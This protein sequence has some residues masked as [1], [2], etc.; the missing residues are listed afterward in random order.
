MAAIVEWKSGSGNGSWFVNT[1]WLGDAVPTANSDVY[2]YGGSGNPQIASPGAVAAGVQIGY[3]LAGQLT[4]TG[5]GT[6]NSSSAS[7]SF[8][9]LATVTGAGSQWNAGEIRVGANANGTSGTLNITNGGLMTGN[10]ARVADDL[11]GPDNSIGTV[12][13]D[14][15][16]WNVTGQLFLGNTGHSKA[17]FTVQNGGTASHTHA[18]VQGPSSGGPTNVTVDGIGSTWTLN[19]SQVTDAL[20]IWSNGATSTVNIVNGASV[21]VNSGTGTVRLSGSGPTVLN[22]GNGGAAGALNA[23]E[24]TGS[25][26]AT[27]N[28]NHTGVAALTANLTGNLTISKLG[29]GTM[30]LTG[31]NTYTGTTTI[32]EGTLR[33]A[34]ATA[35]L[36]TG[37]VLNNGTLSI[38]SDGTV[39]V[40]NAISGS[41]NLQKSGLGTLT[42][43]GVN[44][45]AGGTSIT[46]GYIN[47]ASLSNFGTG[48][49]TCDG[50]G[51]QWA[52][53]NTVDISAK[54]NAIGAGGASFN[55]N[56]NNVTLATAL[57]GS[58]GI[59]K[60]GP[61][62]LTLNGANQYSGGTTVSGGTLKKGVA[63]ALP[64]N[65]ALTVNG[66][67]LD[68]NNFNT[69]VSSLSV[70]D[71]S[72]I[73]GTA[74]LTVNQSTNTTSSGI[75]TGAGGL[76][77]QG[78]GRLALA[79]AG[80]TYTGP[81]N[82][83]GGALEIQN[84]VSFNSPIF[85][86]APAALTLNIA[87]DVR[88]LQGISGGGSIDVTGTAKTARLAGDN[89]G[90]TGTFTLP[91]TARGMMW[92]HADAGSAAAS[93]NLS[94]EFAAI[95]TGFGS[96]TTHLGQLTGTNS[97]TKLTTFG[98]TGI[99]TL[100]VG[101][102]NTN[103]SFAGAIAN[104]SQG[105]GG[106]GVVAL[107]KVGTGKLT[108]AGANTYTGPTSVLGGT[109]EIQNNNSFNSPI[110]V[111]APAA[112]TLNIANDVK[113]LQ[114]VSGAGDINVIGTGA[115]ARLAGDNSGFTG[116][117][118]LPNTARG[119]MWSHANAGSAL[120]SWNLSG[121]FVA[122]ET[123]AGNTTTK[124]GALSGTN[125]NTDISAF[126]GSGVKTLEIGALG[127][128][129][130]FAGDFR[131]GNA[132]VALRKVGPGTLTL[133]GTDA[134]TGGTTVDGGTLQIT[135]SVLG[136]ATVNAGG[137]LSLAGM[138]NI[139]ND[140]TVNGGTLAGTGVIAG[141]VHVTSGTLAPGD[142]GTGTLSI[143]GGGSLT[144]S[145]A[146]TTF[147]ELSQSIPIGLLNCTNITYDGTLRVSL[148]G[149]FQPI[150]GQSFSIFATS[151]SST[152]TFDS[153]VFDQPGY[154]GTF[155]YTT[156]SLT[157]VPE[158]SACALAAFAL[159]GFA[160]RRRRSRAR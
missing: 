119:M 142:D 159:G 123:G 128:N 6:L 66:G 135:G 59:T 81:T 82:V 22:I 43:S 98:G 42:L 118:T 65:T 55:T 77:K 153:I 63:S 150:E 53:G 52:A 80:T 47:F 26:S 115:T 106:T 50:G 126:G 116:T 78:T 141:D 71:G 9:G 17:N 127:T 108:L 90:F 102:L 12:M 46:G 60:F 37:N 61:G 154:A 140:V 120:A 109:L 146:S 16:T 44:T 83:L 110:S 84:N 27:V 100:E 41:G 45:Y 134:H 3:G 8:S 88:L 104:D 14:A 23:G 67:V 117:F 70:P 79:G 75:M 139:N 97:A 72:V 15:G 4:V 94:G 95:E 68:L 157:I 156:G 30:I 143:L 29:S 131:N 145:S 76:T 137:T 124:L 51:L 74:T 147:I 107:K 56:G 122:I 155:N 40:P 99:K 73:L 33:I 133:A 105:G 87:N 36:G 114:G 91:A 34:G 58:G 125:P 149:G 18:I 1:N 101:A 136:T 48:K 144:L 86:D 69:T 138:A 38:Q 5:G 130:T 57:S 96:T 21:S 11:S 39:A 32:H 111:D 103:T 158:P 129:T 20:Q 64:A 54:L 31:A 148:I 112:L 24:V 121:Q 25:G 160:L 62:T 2:I 19:S 151:P 35:S 93:W 85:V 7:I 152:G 92:S 132:T 13:V 10:I 113:L 49:I 89:S 28:F